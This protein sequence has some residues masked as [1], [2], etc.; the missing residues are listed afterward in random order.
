MNQIHRCH[1][2]VSYGEAVIACKWDMTHT[3]LWMTWAAEVEF[4]GPDSLCSVVI[5]SSSKTILDSTSI[6]PCPLPLL[7]Q[8]VLD[9]LCILGCQ[10]VSPQMCTL[11]G[12][13]HQLQM[14]GPSSTVLY[15]IKALLQPQ[16]IHML[17]CMAWRQWLSIRSPSKPSLTAHCVQSS[18]LTSP[19]ALHRVS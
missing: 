7:T 17:P 2:W 14:R 8:S 16:E 10:V 6:L 13:H 3:W 4:D 9:L 12:T 5:A 18:L 19:S 15:G 1:V 11:P